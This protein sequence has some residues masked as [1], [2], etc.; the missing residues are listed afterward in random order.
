MPT[1]RFPSRLGRR[2]PALLAETLHHEVDK[3]LQTGDVQFFGLP[4]T[5]VSRTVSPFSPILRRQQSVHRTRQVLTGVLRHCR[6][7]SRLLLNFSL[8]P[9]Y[10]SPAN[11]RKPARSCATPL[12]RHAPAFRGEVP[13]CGFRKFKA[14]GFK[15]RVRGYKP[16]SS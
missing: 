7:S 3:F 4:C 12:K 14:R 9:K 5:Q 2:H 10:S 13:S 6:V 11:D 15:V 16:T 1:K 8:P